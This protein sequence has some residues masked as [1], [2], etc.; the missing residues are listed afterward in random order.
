MRYQPRRDHRQHPATRVFQAIRIRVN[1]ELTR[2][3]MALR[4]AAHVLRPSG[5]LVV[6]SFHSLE[7]RIVKRFMR[8]AARR[9]AADSPA[10]R[11]GF[12][13]RLR[14]VCKPVRPGR[15]ETRRN[16]RSRSAI[17]RVAEKLM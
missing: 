5:R 3:E 8:A 4:G 14:I 7:D 10:V 11:E 13:G 6:V 12:E 16:P 17:M 9:V 2:L 1:D 15:S